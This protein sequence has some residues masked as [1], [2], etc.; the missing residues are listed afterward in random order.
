VY[1]QGNAKAPERFRPAEF[2]FDGGQ[3]RHVPADPG[4]FNFSL[5][6]EGQVSHIIHTIAI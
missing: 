5:R 2:L 4:Y 6:S 3:Q 1:A